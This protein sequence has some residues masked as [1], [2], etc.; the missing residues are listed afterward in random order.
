MGQAPCESLASETR[1][2][3]D[4]TAQSSVTGEKRDPDLLVMRKLVVQSMNPTV[5]N[6]WH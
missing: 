6:K 3:M 4:C 5:P 2:I 1:E